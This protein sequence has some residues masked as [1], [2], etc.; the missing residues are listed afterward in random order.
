VNVAIT[1]VKHVRVELNN[2]LARSI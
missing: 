1:N 2:L